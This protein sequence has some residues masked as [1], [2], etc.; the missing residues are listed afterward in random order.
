[1]VQVL[2][3]LTPSRSTPPL[4]VVRPMPSPLP[5]PGRRG[6]VFRP[7]GGRAGQFPQLSGAGVPAASSTATSPAATTV[8]QILYSSA[9]NTVAGLATANSAALVTSSTG[10]P[11]LAAM[12][13]GQLIVG[14]TRGTPTRAGPP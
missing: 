12:P 1:M 6:E 13:S 3:R 11:S 5:P 8:S 4:S 2:L 10:V 7:L 9:T 14:N